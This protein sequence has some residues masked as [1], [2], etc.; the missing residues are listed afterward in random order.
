[1]RA[2]TARQKKKKKKGEKRRDTQAQMGLSVLGYPGRLLHR[3]GER[4]SLNMINS[5]GLIRNAT[6]KRGFGVRRN[7]VDRVRG[8]RAR[9]EQEEGVGRGRV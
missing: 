9:G 3:V 7:V 6:M 4:I 1:M 2:E 5:A 8:M